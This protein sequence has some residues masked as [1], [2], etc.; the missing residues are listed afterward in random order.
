M[1]N[2]KSKSGDMAESSQHASSSKDME[3]VLI[4]ECIAKP[5]WDQVHTERFENA[6]LKE[7]EALNLA[8]SFL[9]EGW[10]D[11][12]KKK[13]KFSLKSKS[14]FASPTDKE[15]FSEA[16]KGVVPE[17]TKKNNSWAEKTFLVW[18]EERNKAVPE[19]PV[20]IDLLSGH[21]PTVLC[22]YLRYLFLKFGEV[23]E[24]S[25]LLL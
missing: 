18:I 17:N 6:T 12:P 20:P 19:D 22:K 5:V 16:A 2:C 3:D 9:P 7:V 24:K 13:L 8:D 23:L 15:K 11:P 4:D 21:Y 25:I 14:R 1:K 10:L